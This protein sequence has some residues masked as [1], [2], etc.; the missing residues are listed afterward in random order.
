MWQIEKS[1]HSTYIDRAS[2]QWTSGVG[3]FE[4]G[5]E[6]LGQIFLELK[7]L[8]HAPREVLHGFAGTSAG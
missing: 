2:H 1:L 6:V 8:H 3:F 7:H 5:P 4:D